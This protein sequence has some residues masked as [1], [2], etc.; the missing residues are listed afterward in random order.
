MKK[1]KII[2][3]ICVTFLLSAINLYGQYLPPYHNIGSVVYDSSDN[4]LSS[5]DII[6]LV[7]D[8]LD[9]KQYKKAKTMVTIGDISRTTGFILFAIA[10]VLDEFKGSVFERNSQGKININMPAATAAASGLV[11]MGGGYIIKK[12]GSEMISELLGNINASVEGQQ[13][14]LLMRVSF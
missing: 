12:R 7:G 6:Y 5:E 10:C 11:L 14:G 13:F 8:G 4:T 2:G 1:Y 9:Y 3:I